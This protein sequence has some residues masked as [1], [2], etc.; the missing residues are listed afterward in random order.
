VVG[1]VVGRW[2]A[3]WWVWAWAWWWVSSRDAG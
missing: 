3:W 1:L 2:W